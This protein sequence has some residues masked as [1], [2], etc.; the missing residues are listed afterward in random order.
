VLELALISFHDTG[1]PFSCNIL[2][3]S[4][5]NFSYVMT[6]MDMKK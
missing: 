6:L 5:L 1:L 3:T 4:L 2:S